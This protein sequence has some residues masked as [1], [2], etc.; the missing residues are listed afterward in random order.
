M[1]MI[2]GSFLPLLLWSYGTAALMAAFVR[3][4]DGGAWSVLLTFWLGGAAMVFLLAL[5]IHLPRHRGPAHH[6]AKAVD[7]PEPILPAS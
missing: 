6:A 7:G 1:T 4:F 2:T 5:L 3:H